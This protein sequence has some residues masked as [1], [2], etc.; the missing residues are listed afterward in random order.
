M[1]CI[2][3]KPKHDIKNALG[4]FVKYTCSQHVT[5]GVN[6]PYN[7]PPSRRATPTSLTC[8]ADFPKTSFLFIQFQ[9]TPIADRHTQN[10][11]N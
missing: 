3:S 10:T 4:L 5:L 1:T 6:H 2:I 11:A 9:M 7:P 8:H